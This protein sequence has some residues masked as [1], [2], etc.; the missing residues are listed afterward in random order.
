[1]LLMS[2]VPIMN[3]VLQYRNT[4]FTWKCRFLVLSFL[5]SLV[6]GNVANWVAS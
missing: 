2:M 6:V 3:S 4:F 5:V 1:L